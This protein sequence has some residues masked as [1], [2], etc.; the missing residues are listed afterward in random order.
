MIPVFTAAI[1]LGLLA[2]PAR[3]DQK[4]DPMIAS[5]AARIVSQKIGVIRG[6]FSWKVK[7]EEIVEPSATF[8]PRPASDF[9]V[10]GSIIT[11]R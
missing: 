4:Y 1:A 7:L 8:A 11:L 5:A 6:G 3:A 10:T 9:T 2:L